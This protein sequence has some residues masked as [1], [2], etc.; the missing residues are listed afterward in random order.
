MRV[1]PV[2]QL[3]EVIWSAFEAIAYTSVVVL[4]VSLVIVAALEVRSRMHS[5]T[6]R[7]ADER[8]AVRR[9][10]SGG[11]SGRVAPATR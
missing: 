4:A 9:R 5:K 3:N 10:D 1:D 2:S 8:A 6:T 7:D 11:R